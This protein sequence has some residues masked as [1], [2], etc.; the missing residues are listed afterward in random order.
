MSDPPD[1]RGPASLAAA[2]AAS[3]G[4]NVFL[5]Y[6]CARCSAG[7]PA[8]GAMDLLPHQVIQLV[9]LGCVEELFRIRGPWLCAGCQTCSSRC[10]NGID[11][12]G[13][14]DAVRQVWPR[15][16][17]EGPPRRIALF[18]R[19]FVSQVARWGRVFELGLVA[20]YQLVR[21][22]SL[23]EVSLGLQMIRKGK[24]RWFPRRVSRIKPDGNILRK[25]PGE[26]GNWEWK[27]GL[28]QVLEE[29]V[30][31]SGGGGVDG[32]RQETAP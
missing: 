10:P 13:V 31:S 24:F 8:A 17:L 21:R 26:L 16:R 27:P 30:E 6:Q 14:M 5:C 19:M 12:A 32:G 20:W 9:K 18:H 29:L 7:C 22:P 2:I 15:E 28:A 1:T 4:E 3:C 25:R 11:V 23:P